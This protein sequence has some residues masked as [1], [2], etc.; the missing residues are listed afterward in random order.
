MK[1][2]YIELTDEE[3]KVLDVFL[4]YVKLKRELK[5]ALFHG[6]FDICEKNVSDPK[7]KQV[8]EEVKTRIGII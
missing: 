6:I 7:K 2:I 4:R 5:K 3:M 1:K 8:I